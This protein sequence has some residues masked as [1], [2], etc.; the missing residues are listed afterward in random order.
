MN[1]KKAQGTV[2]YQGKQIPYYGTVNTQSREE[3]SRSCEEQAAKVYKSLTGEEPESGAAAL[4]YLME[5]FPVDPAPR[6]DIPV[7]RAGKIDYAS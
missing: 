6:N 5:R 4:A 3:W 7:K 2:E 1:M